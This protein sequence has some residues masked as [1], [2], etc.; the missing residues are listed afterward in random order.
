MKGLCRQFARNDS[1]NF[2]QEWTTTINSSE[3]FLCMRLIEIQLS[4]REL[5]DF[6]RIISFRDV[7]IKLRMVVLP[8]SANRFRYAHENAS[9]IL[10]NFSETELKMKFTSFAS[11]MELRQKYIHRLEVCFSLLLRLG[12]PS[13]SYAVCCVVSVT[14]YYVSELTFICFL[15]SIIFHMSITANVFLLHC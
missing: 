7:L 11:V 9:K 13:I 15:F 10:C 6:V 2:N 4:D 1:D 8:L 5:F 3:R 14:I 12:L